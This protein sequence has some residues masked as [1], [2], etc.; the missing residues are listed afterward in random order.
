MGKENSVRPD[1]LADRWLHGR[2]LYRGEVCRSLRFSKAAREK[3]DAV[4]DCAT[5]E[6]PSLLQVA[7]RWFHI[8]HQNFRSWSDVRRNRWPASF[9][10]R[11]E[12]LRRTHR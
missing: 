8:S 4:V 1:G 9:L 3:N 2:R 6:R 10:P 5:V 12:F 11:D 7:S